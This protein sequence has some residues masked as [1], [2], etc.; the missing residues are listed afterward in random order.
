MKTRMPKEIINI[1]E[2][3]GKVYY[4]KNLYDPRFFNA[5]NT[6][7]SAYDP[8]TQPI[9]GWQL[10]GDQ[11]IVLNQTITILQSDGEIF[12]GLVLT[13]VYSPV[14]N[15]TLVTL[16]GNSPGTNGISGTWYYSDRA[17]LNGE[18]IRANAVTH[19]LEYD[20]SIDNEG[21]VLFSVGING[22]LS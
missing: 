13:A 3:Y 21:S 14:F 12:T 17:Y 16:A 22:V 10:D 2:G 6:C 4:R 5:N 18:D 8:P 19:T 7:N 20:P 9:N 11:S 1:Y 15:N